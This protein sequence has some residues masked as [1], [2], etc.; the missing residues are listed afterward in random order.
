MKV[1]TILNSESGFN[2]H[3]KMEKRDII[4]WRGNDMSDF[5]VARALFFRP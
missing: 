2:E 3:S 4:N 5:K 1:Y